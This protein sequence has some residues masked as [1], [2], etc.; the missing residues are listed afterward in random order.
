MNTH[1]NNLLKSKKVTQAESC[2]LLDNKVIP[3]QYQGEY[4]LVVK[5]A[6]GGYVLDYWSKRVTAMENAEITVLYLNNVALK[7]NYSCVEYGNTF[8]T[9]N[10]R[11][12]EA[13]VLK[14]SAEFYNLVSLL[15][16]DKELGEKIN[17]FIYREMN[18]LE[19]A[20]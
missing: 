7:M 6:A 19:V 2:R 16:A 17:H 18:V 13:I 11:G 1:L 15:K 14:V 8:Y 9:T 12:N 4:F 20:L 3:Y 10:C 5:G